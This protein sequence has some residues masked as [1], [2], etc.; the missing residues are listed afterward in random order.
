MPP[1]L[2]LGLREQRIV[3]CGEHLGRAAR[4]GP[5]ETLGHGHEH[6][7]VN[8]RELGLA[9]TTDYRHDAVALLEAA[10]TRPQAGYLT[11]ELEPRNVL[12]GA[13]WSGIEPTPLHHVRSVQAGRLDPDQ[14]LAGPRFGVGVVFDG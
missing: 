11:C 9:A 12:R 6:A 14:D 5:I 3:G 7:L 2:E 8:G 1:R 10:G 4:L 13:G